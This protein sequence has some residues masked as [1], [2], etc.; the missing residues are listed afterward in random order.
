MLDGRF[1]VLL[2]LVA[3]LP[4]LLSSAASILNDG[5]TFKVSN[6]AKFVSGA[7]MLVNG[8]NTALVFDVCAMSAVA[9][10]NSESMVSIDIGPNAT[11]HN[12]AQLWFICEER[13]SPSIVSIK[14][15]RSHFLNA[16]FGLANI[17]HSAL[18]LQVEITECNFTRQGANSVFHIR[19]F[20]VKTGSADVDAPLVTTSG[21]AVLWEAVIFLHNVTISGLGSRLLID[22]CNITAVFQVPGWNAKVALSVILHSCGTTI[23]RQ[24]ALVISN[25]EVYL[26]GPRY[27]YG[28]LHYKSPLSIING[29]RYLTANTRWEL[30]STAANQGVYAIHFSTSS[31]LTIADGSQYLINNDRWQVVGKDAYAIFLI[32]SSCYVTRGSQFLI[33]DTNWTISGTGADVCGIRFATSPLSV[34]DGSQFVMVRSHWLNTGVQVRWLDW[35]TASISDS[36]PFVSS[37]VFNRNRF[38]STSSATFNVPSNVFPLR[39]CNTVASTSNHMLGFGA[40]GLTSCVADSSCT[41]AVD[42]LP[43]SLAL[44]VAPSQD[45]NRCHCS[46]NATAQAVYASTVLTGTVWSYMESIPW[47][48]ETCWLQFPPQPTSVPP[49]LIKTLTL[50]RSKSQSNTRTSSSIPTASQTPSLPESSSPTLVLPETE[51][52]NALTVSATPKLSLRNRSVTLEAAHRLTT[53]SK[54]FSKGIDQLASDGAIP[55]LVIGKV[56][57]AIVLASSTAASAVAAG[58]VNPTGVTQVLRITLV[59]SVVNCAFSDGEEELEPERLELPLQVRVDSGESAEFGLYVG[60]LLLSTGC[61]ALAPLAILV[62]IW[63]LGDTTKPWVV[64]LQ[65]KVVSTASFLGLAY[66]G[67]TSAKVLALVFFHP[68]TALE[69]ALAVCCALL[70]ILVSSALMRKTVSSVRTHDTLDIKGMD[71]ATFSL[72]F[73]AARDPPM[74]RYRLYFFEELLVTTLFMFC[75]GIR[76]REGN[77]GYVAVMIGIVAVFHFIFLVTLRPYACRVELACALLSAGVLVSMAVLAVAATIVTTSVGLRNALGYLAVVE[78]VVIFFQSAVLAI[79][80]YAK[81][82]QR[83]LLEHQAR[84]EGVM[85]DEDSN[86]VALLAI[87]EEGTLLGPATSTM[88][89]LLHRER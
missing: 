78:S 46:C 38:T 19:P 40:T 60:S 61:F 69:K 74:L 45:A 25:S 44:S 8:S 73:E 4:C 23:T 59:M 48:N 65:A 15:H 67:P 17:A 1:S 51:T 32:S 33:R 68:S 28:F 88:N 41:L 76:P 9:A 66:F 56:P 42:C 63:R 37:I 34:T 35:Q 77:C 10:M 13:P 52:R 81:G 83:R 43:S 2:L 26:E 85:G 30:R 5:K 11:F 31:T 27:V 71:Y 54:S 6:L 21:S 22:R 39:R 57:T 29:S 50:K 87:P 36:T 75:D 20:A 82:Q 86:D 49:A 7:D 53:K 3:A 24:G 55:T 58:I 18:M 80:L 79:Y 47:D 64:Q 16:A 72:L 12:G 14:I 70:F 89:P 62:G 84:V